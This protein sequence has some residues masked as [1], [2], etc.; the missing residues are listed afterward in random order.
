MLQHRHA[1]NA[2]Q[3]VLHLLQ[4]RRVRPIQRTAE[5]APPAHPQGLLPCPAR[6]CEAVDEHARQL[7]CLATVRLQ[8][9][10]RP[11]S[12][13]C[14]VEKPVSAA[15]ERIDQSRRPVSYA[16]SARSRRQPDRR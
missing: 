16:T 2:L 6:Q 15:I 13:D 7:E 9:E 12:A 4:E 3:A 10:R 11:H 14:G 8:A 5:C 1:Q